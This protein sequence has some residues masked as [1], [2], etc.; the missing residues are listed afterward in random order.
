MSELADWETEGARARPASPDDVVRTPAP[1]ALRATSWI[2]ALLLV[3]AAGVFWATSLVDGG[4]EGSQSQLLF[5]VTLLVVIGVG[6]AVSGIV[7][8]LL[9]LVAGALLRR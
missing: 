6:L 5:R 7:A 9:R 4:P 3:A 2:G 1:G 8:L